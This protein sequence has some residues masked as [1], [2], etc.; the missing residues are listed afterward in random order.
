MT[1]APAAVILA[2]G[3]ADYAVRN[4]KDVRRTGALLLSASAL[5]A[6]S[7][8]PFLP[9]SK[10]ELMRGDAEFW[11]NLASAYEYKAQP[12]RALWT[13]EEA[14][15][16]NPDNYL[17]HE[18]KAELLEDL[19]AD[20]NVLL[21]WLR[22]AARR[23]PDEYSAHMMLAEASALA[24]REGEALQSYRRALEL[25]PGSV[26]VHLQLG[27]LLGRM[28][29]HGE[30]KRVFLD[31]LSLSPEDLKLQYNCAVAC[32]VLGEREEALRRLKDVTAKDPDFGKA[33]RLIDQLE[34]EEQ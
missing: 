8:S 10:A 29:R 21:D 33:R 6:V 23:F 27:A 18:K 17:R 13:V 12:D 11:A 14:I 34:R 19:S 9:L 28:G 4:F 16:L 1:M 32:F 24:G 20:A 26:E 31:G 5:F 22:H 25:A 2:G 7:F 30:A 15:R 3:A